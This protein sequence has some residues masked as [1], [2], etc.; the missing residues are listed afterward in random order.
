MTCEN[1]TR[2]LA[3]DPSATPDVLINLSQHPNWGV[4]WRVAQNPNTPP[5][6][7]IQ[8][9]T[10]EEF[11]VRKHVAMNP[12]TPPHILGGMLHDFPGIRSGLARNPAIHPS[13]L[14]HLL[15]EEY[16]EVLQAVA[17]HPSTPHD[18]ITTLSQDKDRV[19]R[20]YVAR[21]PSSPYGIWIPKYGRVLP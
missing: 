17:C 7:L 19:V 11:I 5:E 4:R 6:I 2:D 15:K 14:K 1:N 10:D 18:A 3:E 9:S 8:L 20:L 12:N 16:V 21:N 13:I